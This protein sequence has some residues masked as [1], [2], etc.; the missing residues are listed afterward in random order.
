MVYLPTVHE[1]LIYFIYIYMVNV[2]KSTIH[3][4]YV[5]EYQLV[6]LVFA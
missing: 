6:Q 3:G 5:D 4:S 1:W 2:G